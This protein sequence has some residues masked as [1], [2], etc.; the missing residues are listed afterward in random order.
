MVVLNALWRDPGP[1]G[2]GLLIV[3]IGVPMYFWF[4]RRSS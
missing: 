2:A 1:T 3:A 4:G